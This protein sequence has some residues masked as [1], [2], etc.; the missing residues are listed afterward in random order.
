MA[1]WCLIL[2]Y[3]ADGQIQKCIPLFCHS[4]DD[5]VNKTGHCQLKV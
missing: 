3:I 1:D 5:A 2:F 4:F